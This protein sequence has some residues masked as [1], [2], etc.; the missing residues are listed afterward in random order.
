MNLRHFNYGALAAAAVAG[1]LA[2][3]TGI[4]QSGHSDPKSLGGGVIIGAGAG[5][6]AGLL[7]PHKTDGTLNPIYNYA[8]SAAARVPGPAGTVIREVVQAA[9]TLPPVP[10]GGGQVAAAV[11]PTPTPDGNSLTALL[12]Y[13]EQLGLSHLVSKL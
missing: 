10:A 9:E 11:T 13:A 8:L 12:S 7:P 1:A 4:L 2:V 5:L 3:V 6:L